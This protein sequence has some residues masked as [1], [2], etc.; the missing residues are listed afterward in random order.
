M[1][2][3]KIISLKVE[4]LLTYSWRVLLTPGFSTWYIV[5]AVTKKQGNIMSNF[6]A[7]GYSFEAKQK[8]I[9]T[10]K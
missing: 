1:M 4:N 7:I 9:K 8:T 3:L 5:I 6:F 10:L 2:F